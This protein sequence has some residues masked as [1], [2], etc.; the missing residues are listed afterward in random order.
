M[1][2]AFSLMGVEGSSGVDNMSG[3]CSGS[4]HLHFQSIFGCI[5]ENQGYPRM[6]LFSPSSVRK[7]RIV[8]HSVLVHV[9]RSV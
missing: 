8:R 9:I 2:Q 4:S 5:D 6:T 1:V 3:S 7:K